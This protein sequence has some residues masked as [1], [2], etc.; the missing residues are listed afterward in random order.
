MHK[1][2][3]LLHY[4]V[5]PYLVF[6][7]GHLPS[8]AK[9]ED[10]RA[11]S[12]EENRR[13]GM[14]LLKA[15]RAKDAEKLFQ[16]A[17]DVT[18]EMA[19]NLIEEL[20][21]NNIA[22]VVA[23]YEADA[24]LVYLE[25]QG[26]IDGIISEDSDLLVFGAKCLITKLTKYG[27][28]IEIN[29]RDF[30]ACREVSF[31]GWSDTD[32]RRMAIL[33]GCDYLDGINDV[34]LKTAYRLIRKYKTPER[35]VQML[36]FEGKRQV[37]ENYL[38]E[39]YRAELT[40]LHQRVFCPTKQE[41][42]LLT[43]AEPST[44]LENMPFIGAALEP[45][46]ARAIA[47]GDFNPITKKP[48]VVKHWS[49][50]KSR[51]LESRRPAVTQA[52]R[53]DSFFKSKEHRRIPMG[54]MDR[55][56][57]TVDPQRVAALTQGGL[58]PIVYPLPRPYL[59]EQ[60]TIARLVTPGLTNASGH[61][62]SPLLSRRQ[63]EPGGHSLTRGSKA[64]PLPPRRA[65]ERLKGPIDSATS[66]KGHRTDSTHQAGGDMSTDS[67]VSG[68]GQRPAKKPRLC[69]DTH[70]GS[71]AMAGDGASKWFAKPAKRMEGYLLSDD[72]IEE[73]LLTLPDVS[74]WH[75]MARPRKEIS[76]F[77]E[78]SQTSAE[79]ATTTESQAS[80]ISGKTQETAP[81]DSLGP[82]LET[83]AKIEEGPKDDAPVCLGLEKFSYNAISSQIAP[84]HVASSKRRSSIPT[85]STT[86]SRRG[87]SIFSPAIS[88]SSTA[89]STAASRPTSLQ[90]IQRQA[91]L[92]SYESPV[93]STKA[94]ISPFQAPKVHAT[95]S[96]EPV[97]PS[98]VPL[99]K[100]DL[101]E[102]DALNRS[103]GSEDQLILE[104]EAENEQTEPDEAPGLGP[105]RSLDLFKFAAV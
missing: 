3:M 13:R 96:S 76:I 101:A 102:V 26:I 71:D 15:G 27:E 36:R 10:A 81:S 19:R 57:F 40:F 50:A 1:V 54:E 68:T 38:V 95:R 37:S 100:V 23:P 45:T 56:C 55:N 74:G 62:R 83:A 67:L 63:S 99:P 60:S 73:A 88:T 44:G 98:F 94:N 72:S 22:Y 24:Q 97:N 49:P 25:R 75:S 64:S 58:V 85:P 32:F 103:C 18:P 104:S 20:K 53:I 80:I 92:R 91:M 30:A 31:T 17:V 21:K 65:S 28:C 93:R 6:D 66:N 78:D 69:A 84:S 90:R 59:D 16:K 42:V 12:R 51:S 8:K 43:E 46:L 89:P 47:V 7:G 82:E 11:K 79:T 35:V 33:S 39:F 70:L 86:T 105:V 5:T 87:S 41:V 48:I 61:E 52:K 4:K 29:R 14:E 34:G 9:T 77:E 2:R